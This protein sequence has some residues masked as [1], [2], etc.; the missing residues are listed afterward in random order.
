M[1]PVTI[2]AAIAGFI[3][4]GRLA[5]GCYSYY[6]ARHNN[7]DAEPPAP[8]VHTVVEKIVEHTETTADGTKV[9]TKET[10]ITTDDKAA[11]HHT[12]KAGKEN[13]PDDV[14][15]TQISGALDPLGQVVTSSVAAAIDAFKVAGAAFHTKHHHK[16]HHHKPAQAPEH[17]KEATGWLHPVNTIKSWFSWGGEKKDIADV[18]QHNKHPVLISSAEEAESLPA[19]PS[20]TSPMLARRN[21]APN[22]WGNSFKGVSSWFKEHSQSQI[23]SMED[24]PEEDFIILINEIEY[25]AKGDSLVPADIELMGKVPCYF[26]QESEGQIIKTIAAS[27]AA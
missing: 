20:E 14:D 26:Y 1:D 13:S 2:S 6:K 27:A 21:S 3:A 25:V 9:T 5:M 24:A 10:I 16:D 17:K 8:T 11:P 18:P 19:T 4:L 7:H 12:T 23:S 22:G 15:T